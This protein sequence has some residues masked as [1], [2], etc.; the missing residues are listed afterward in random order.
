[1]PTVTLYATADTFMEAREPTTNYNS[2]SYIYSGEGNNLADHYQRS[3]V[4]FDLS[5]IPSNA[6]VNSAVLSLYCEADLADNARTH[7][8]FRTKRAWVE[9]QATWNIFSTGNSWQTAGGFGYNDCEQTDIGSRDFTATETLNEYKDF[10]LTVSAVQAMISGSFTNNGFFIKADTELNDS[11]RFSSREVAG[12]DQDPKLVIDYTILSGGGAATLY[13]IA[14]TYIDSW[15]P[16]E[17]RN[18]NEFIRVGESNLEVSTGRGL[19]KFDLSSI[20]TNARVSSAT[21]SL[22]CA[23]D[24]SSNARTFR[25]YRSLRAWVETEATWNIFSTGNNWQTAGGFGANDTEQTDIGTRAFTATET[26]NAYKDF[27]LTASAVEEMIQGLFTN[28]GFFVKGDT[29]SDDAYL[30]DTREA[31]GTTKDPKLAIVWRGPA[32]AGS[33][34]ITDLAGPMI[35]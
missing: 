11:Y 4:K 32:G 8:V 26:L 3:L 22:Y 2:Y 27:T 34:V 35:V 30:F 25:V 19:V 29:E 14:D 10:T 28:N 15:V 12:T 9:A 7:R 31:A 18:A 5:S 23:T 21:L 6:S 1:M 20:P 33:V 24:E 13:S 17:N 16:L